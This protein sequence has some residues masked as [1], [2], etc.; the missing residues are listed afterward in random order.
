M[1]AIETPSSAAAHLHLKGQTRNGEFL[2]TIKMW[3]L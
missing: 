2:E 1:G 3:Q